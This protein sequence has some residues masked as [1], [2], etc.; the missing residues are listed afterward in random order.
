MLVVDDDAE[1]RLLVRSFLELAGFVV[2]EA[3]SAEEALEI[4]ADGR[5]QA[6]V[7]DE[8]MPGLSGTELILALSARGIDCPAIVYTGEPHLEG[9]ADDERSLRYLSK[10]F[11]AEDLVDRVR[12]LLDQERPAS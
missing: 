1:Q 2:A 9:R 7:T 4:A 5:I 10:P 12:G 8:R 3:S 6:V 11:R